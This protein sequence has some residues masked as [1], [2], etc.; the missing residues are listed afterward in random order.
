MGFGDVISGTLLAGGIAAALARRERTGKS[1]VV[2]GSLMA[3]G[4]WAMQ[5]AVVA[6]S[7]YGVDDLRLMGLRDRIRNPLVNTYRA[8]DDRVISLAMMESQRFWG[9]FCRA[10]GRP[11]LEHD[12]R[13]ATAELREENAASCVAALDEIFAQRTTDQW[14]SALSQQE[15]AWMVVGVAR[16]LLGD[17][18]AW[19][20]DYLQTV[21]YGP[22]GAATFVASPI[23]FDGMPPRIRPGPEH[24]ANTEEVLLE[25]GLDWDDLAKLKGDG[26]IS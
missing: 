9:G 21:D 13:F 26:V 8:S 2:D 16:D 10:V 15:G 17:A 4:M 24:G 19:A 23:A 7:L 20:N 6:A 18:Q 11:D 5:P 25:I 14:A 3:S 12:P 1:C 22:M